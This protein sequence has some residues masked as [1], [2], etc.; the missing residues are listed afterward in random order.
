ML[1]PR[2]ARTTSCPPF[3]SP[4]CP[5]DPLRLLLELGVVALPAGEVG[6]KAGHQ[7]R[8]LVALPLGKVALQIEGYQ[9]QNL[10]ASFPP[11]LLFFLQGLVDLVVHP[12]AR[13][14]GSGA[15]Q[16]HLVPKLDPFID[17]IQHYLARQ[18]LVLIQPTPDAWTLKLVTE[19]LCEGLVSRAVADETAVVLCGF[20]K[21]R[22]EVL[23]EA[24]GKAA[25][26]EEIDRQ[27]AGPFKGAVIDD[28]R[29]MVVAT[30]KGAMVNFGG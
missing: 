27:V 3:V 9:G 6:G 12:P 21:D 4:E 11:E 5:H 10:F 8:C 24:L 15:T 13:E 19:T 17:L 7:E 26:A 23:D 16:E 2:P 25:A 14:R 22:G 29:T 30:G 18:D 20:I 1:R 28:A